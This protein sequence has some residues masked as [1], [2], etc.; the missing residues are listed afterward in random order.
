MAGTVSMTWASRSLESRSASSRVALAA[1]KAPLQRA[2][3][4][5]QEELLLTQLE[6]VPRPGDEFLMIDRALQEVGGAGL[7]R[8]QAEAALLVDGDDDDGN[9]GGPV[10]LAEAADELRA[11]HAGHLVVGDDEIGRVRG[12]PLEGLLRL[13]ESL[14]PHGVGNRSREPLEEVPVGNPIVEDYDERHFRMVHPRV[15]AERSP[16]CRAC[17]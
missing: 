15:T 6:Q 14:R 1:L 5:G 4:L 10:E 16:C 8:L 9:L 12:E 3:P 2:R 13:A 17:P 11:V 7:Q